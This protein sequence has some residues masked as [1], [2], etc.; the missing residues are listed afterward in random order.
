MALRPSANSP[1]EQAKTAKTARPEPLKNNLET[2]KAEG[3]R[4]SI[5]SGVVIC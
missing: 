3:E 1:G 4:E 2:R 5:R